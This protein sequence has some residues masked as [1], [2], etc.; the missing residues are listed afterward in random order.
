MKTAAW[1]VVAIVSGL[2]VGFV[3]VTAFERINSLVFPIPAGMDVKD[4]AALS[5]WFETLPAPA[6]LMVLMGWIIGTCFGAY[7]AA[8][9]VA[10]GKVVHALVIGLVF[11]AAAITNLL[12]LKHPMWFNVAAMA[13]FLPAALAGGLVATRRLNPAQALPELD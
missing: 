9:L 7:T 10:V 2:I 3:L 12:M 6:F 13:V 8:R 1:S 5:A 11:Q 4:Q